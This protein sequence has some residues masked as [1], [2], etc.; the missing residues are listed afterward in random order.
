VNSEFIDESG[1]SVYLTEAYAA[2]V[3]K[4]SLSSEHLTRYAIVNLGWVEIAHSG[5][6][7][8]VR[9][10]PTILTAATLAALFY[11][12]A[13]RAERPIKLIIFSSEWIESTFE[14]FHE[15][16]RF[17]SALCP[18]S[19]VGPADQ[20]VRFI[21]QSIAAKDT[22]FA[23]LVSR[24][25]LIAGNVSDPSTAV[26]MLEHLV[27]ARW[28]LVRVDTQ[29][30]A[31]IILGMSGTFRQFNPTWHDHG[32][33]API[34]EFSD[35][36]YGAWVADHHRNIQNTMQVAFDYVD[37]AVSFPRLGEMRLRYECMT[38]P[39]QLSDRS[40]LLVCG[41]IDRPTLDFR[42]SMG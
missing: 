20:R 36:S 19:E 28:S 5:N 17:L 18:N 41:A 21:R 6:W 34:T 10:K 8:T 39:I 13:G 31:S 15:F 16:V 3:L 42:K 23:S 9:C 35:R 26:R 7:T 40:H 12:T 2:E 11:A 22:S 30:A 4:L 27:P 14:S 24:V 38:C 25:E 33:G 1:G 32:E 29:R 37:A